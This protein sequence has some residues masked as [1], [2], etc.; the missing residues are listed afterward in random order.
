MGGSQKEMRNNVQEV[1]D[2]QAVESGCFE[3]CCGLLSTFSSSTVL[4]TPLYRVWQSRKCLLLWYCTARIAFLP[5]LACVQPYQ[6]GKHAGNLS[7]GRGSRG[8]PHQSHGYISFSVN[9]VRTSEQEAVHSYNW[10]E[11][12]TMRPMF[13][14]VSHESVASICIRP[15]PICSLVMSFQCSL[16]LYSA[17]HRERTFTFIYFIS[18]LPRPR[19]AILAA[20]RQS[21]WCV[22][23]KEWSAQEIINC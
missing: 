4:S 13:S 7:E 10:E 1:S 12:W 3:W 9:F 17:A 15:P 21:S 19:T 18:F 22:M 11:I 6:T 14:L 5:V 16:P 20:S 23:L 2:R 8:N